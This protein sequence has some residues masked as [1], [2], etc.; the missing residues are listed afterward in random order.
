MSASSRS[1]FCKCLKSRGAGQRAYATSFTCRTV[2]SIS[3]RAFGA[4]RPQHPLILFRH[5]PK[6]FIDELLDALSAV[7]FGREDIALRIG[8]DAVDGIELAGLPPAI[9]KAGQYFERVAVENMNFLVRSI[10][11]VDVFLLGIL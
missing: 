11:E 5:R 2:G 6:P 3:Q 10:G 7:G 1:R 9:A 8:G 4:L